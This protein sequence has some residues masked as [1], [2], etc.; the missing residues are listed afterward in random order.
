MFLLQIVIAAGVS[1]CTAPPH[2]WVELTGCVIGY[3]SVGYDSRSSDS[4][5]G[6][7][8]PAETTYVDG[9]SLQ[10]QDNIDCDGVA[11][12]VGASVGGDSYLT[13]DAYAVHARFEHR[14]TPLYNYSEDCGPAD[15][16]VNSTHDLS[17]RINVTDEIFVRQTTVTSSGSES[18]DFVVLP[19]QHV[20]DFSFS[21]NAKQNRSA[22]VTWQILSP[23][24][25]DVD[26]DG[27][28]SVADILP[29]IE[30]I[31]S[32]DYNEWADVNCDGA[33]T[34]SDISPFISL[35]AE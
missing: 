18:E 3:V 33:V 15:T 12:W 7:W 6:F 28:L 24:P 29:F 35:I 22:V 31:L 25:G 14:F 8:I 9:I 26:R 16:S 2:E 13:F 32:G 20:L 30:A 1:N 23:A 4:C 34:V 5:V 19:G 27:A 10:A 11:T 21:S 17:V